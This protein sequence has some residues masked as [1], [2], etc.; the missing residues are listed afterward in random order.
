M[1]LASRLFKERGMRRGLLL[2]LSWLVVTPAFG[3]QAAPGQAPG[4][5]EAQPPQEPAI[6]KAGIDLVSVTATVRD[7]R[8]GL[9]RGVKQGAFAVQAHGPPGP[10]PGF[11]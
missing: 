5:T 1:Y 4:T 7:R 3:Q 10:Q 9:V 8:G 2:L 11:P 6:F